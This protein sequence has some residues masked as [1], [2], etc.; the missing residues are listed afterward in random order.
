M[1]RATDIMHS[2]NSST[3]ETAAFQRFMDKFRNGPLEEDTADSMPELYPL[4]LSRNFSPHHRHRDHTASRSAPRHSKQSE[5]RRGSN[6]RGR[7]GFHGGMD[8]RNGHGD[9]DDDN[10]GNSSGNKDD[11]REFQKFKKFQ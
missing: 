8:R 2:P 6:H 5:P 10:D 1:L 4:P 7:G 9:P 11:F 3:G